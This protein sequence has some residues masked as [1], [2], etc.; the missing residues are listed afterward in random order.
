MMRIQ[1]NNFHI[2]IL[3]FFVSLNRLILL[4]FVFYFK[5]HVTFYKRFVLYNQFV[6]IDGLIGG[7]IVYK[8]LNIILTATD[9]FIVIQPS[10]SSLSRCRK[11]ITMKQYFF[12]DKNRSLYNTK[13]DIK[14][15]VFINITIL[16]QG[17]AS[18][19]Y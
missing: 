7:Q 11:K 3:L 14:P 18:L 16:P 10:I 2:S 17:P 12:S 15:R 1:S 6:I 9:V 5:L 13:E 8:L 19:P 4:Y